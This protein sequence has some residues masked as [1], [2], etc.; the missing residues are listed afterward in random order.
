M[1]RVRSDGFRETCDVE[2]RRVG[3]RIYVSVHHEGTEQV[4]VNEIV[5]TCSLTHGLRT[6]IAIPFLLC[7]SGRIEEC[8][9]L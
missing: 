9:R 1:Q 6:S 5:C 2:R 8:L 3:I 4:N 7:W